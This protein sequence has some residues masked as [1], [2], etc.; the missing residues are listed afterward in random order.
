MNERND[1][2]APVIRATVK[3]ERVAD[4]QTAAAKTLAAIA[5]ATT[6]AP[7][8]ALVGWWALSMVSSD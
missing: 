5:E 2:N 7:V 8:A 4:V 1:M 6:S 3:P